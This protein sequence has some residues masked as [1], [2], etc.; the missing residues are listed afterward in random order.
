MRL[1]APLITAA[2]LFSPV[3]NA[4]LLKIFAYTQPIVGEQK[5]LQVRGKVYFAG[6]ATLA[7]LALKVIDS[8][9]L[10]IHRPS[11]DQQGKFVFELAAGNYQIIADSLDGHL[12]NWQLKASV[13]ASELLENATQPSADKDLIAQN[14]YTQQQLQRVISQQLAIQIQPLSEQLNSLQEKARFQDIIGALGYIFG[15]YG[16]A[17]WWRQRK[18][19]PQS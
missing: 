19:D 16:L 5:A 11:T 6:G 12:A 14:Q 8:E 1:I 18:V 9:G 3:A 10:V 13:E 17:I 2:L 7:N 15:L 4:H